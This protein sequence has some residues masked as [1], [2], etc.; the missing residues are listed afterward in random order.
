MLDG[1]VA[2]LVEVA[3]EDLALRLEGHVAVREQAG[4]DPGSVGRDHSAVTVRGLDGKAIQG[5]RHVEAMVGELI[6]VPDPPWYC[7]ERNPIQR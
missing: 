5:R 1:E 6:E 4:D 3:A 2:Q 7:G